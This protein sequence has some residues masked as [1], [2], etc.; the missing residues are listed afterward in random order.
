MVSEA[1]I[2]CYREASLLDRH[3]GHLTEFLGVQHRTICIR[4]GDTFGKLLSCQ[5]NS[6]C[7]MTSARSLAAMFRDDTIPQ[8][9]LVRL[10][11]QVPFVLVY[12]V[13]SDEQEI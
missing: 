7:V 2:V 3:L 5:E 13:T 9:L 8:D 11:E 12:G 4:N 10:F 6:T 1:T